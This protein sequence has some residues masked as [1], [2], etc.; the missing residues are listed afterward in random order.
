MLTPRS[1]SIAGKVIRVTVPYV[2][3]TYEVGQTIVVN[4]SPQELETPDPEYTVP[5]IIREVVDIGVRVGLAIELPEG[6]SRDLG[7]DTWLSAL[8]KN[9]AG[10]IS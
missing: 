6:F 9:A 2:A 7:S 8:L 4:F 3:Q 5:G 10:D 1:S